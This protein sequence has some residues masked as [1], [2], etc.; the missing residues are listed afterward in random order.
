[1]HHTDCSKSPI[2]KHEPDWATLIIPDEASTDEFLLGVVDVNCKHCGM[3]GSARVD[4]DTI[5]WE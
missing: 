2:G 1:M 5:S 3:S 4:P